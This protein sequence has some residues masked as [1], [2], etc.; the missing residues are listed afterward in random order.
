[1]VCYPWIYCEDVVQRK[2]VDPE[3]LDWG[4]VRR[5]EGGVSLKL[6]LK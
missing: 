2:G 3:R 4:G 1:M 5:L 6:N